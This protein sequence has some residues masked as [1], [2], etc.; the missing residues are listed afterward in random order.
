MPRAVWKGAVSFGK[1][2]KLPEAEEPPEGKVVQVRMPNNS[3]P[4][5]SRLHSPFS[6]CN[7][8]GGVTVGSI[9]FRGARA[10]KAEDL[11]AVLATRENGFL[12]WTRQ[13]LVRS[14]GIRP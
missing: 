13:V 3:S 8:T 4:Q 1:R 5:P 11:K 7:E 6:A 2:P 10:V 14:R 12:P 9:E